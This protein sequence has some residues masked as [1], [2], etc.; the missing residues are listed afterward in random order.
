MRNSDW[1]SGVSKWDFLKIKSVLIKLPESREF[2][3]CIHTEDRWK[4]TSIQ[5]PYVWSLTTHADATPMLPMLL[6][7]RQAAFL[8]I[9]GQMLLCMCRLQPKA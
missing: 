7:R 8:H 9:R 2:L 6:P 1:T 3:D 4:F 5:V